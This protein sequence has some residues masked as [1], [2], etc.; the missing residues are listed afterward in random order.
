MTERIERTEDL[1]LIDMT[2][3]PNPAEEGQVRFLD[4]DIKAFV[5]GSVV[6]LISGSGITEEQ[7]E[8][9]DTLAHALDETCYTEITRTGG[10]VTDIVV[11][12]TDAKLLKVREETITRAAGKVSQILTIQY[13][14]AGV[15]KMR[16]TETFTR[17]GTKITFIDAVRA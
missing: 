2:G 1:Y 13:D 15:E 16:V 6:S 12:A 5:G 3:G 4:A 10:K 17:A 14:G 11:W 8:V 7:H 9:L